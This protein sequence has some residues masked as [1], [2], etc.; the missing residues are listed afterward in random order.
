MGQ[1]Y[2]MAPERG[3]YF[4]GVGETAGATH[5]QA[6]HGRHPPQR[7]GDDLPESL[8]DGRREMIGR[9]GRMR[10]LQPEEVAG[11]GRQAATL[12]VGRAVGVVVK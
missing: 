4:S 12:R 10:R 3:L 1:R 2:A 8:T 7:L 6:V 11:F 5:H 9:V